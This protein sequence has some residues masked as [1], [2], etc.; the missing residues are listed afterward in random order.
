M[1]TVT[2]LP[3]ASSLSVMNAVKG[4][5]HSPCPSTVNTRRNRPL[6]R[7]SNYKRACTRT[8]ATG[9]KLI[10][11]RKSVCLLVGGSIPTSRSFTRLC[12]HTHAGKFL[13]RVAQS[14]NVTLNLALTQLKSGDF[15]FLPSAHLILT[16]SSP[17]PLPLCDSNE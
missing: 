13:L 2:S 1:A 6:R 7:L 5:S 3:A 4:R 11:Q 16:S 9:S 10:A 14:A 8:A 15:R 17:P 12:T